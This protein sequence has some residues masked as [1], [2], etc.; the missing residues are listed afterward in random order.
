MNSLWKM[1]SNQSDALYV[2]PFAIIE[3]EDRLVAQANLEVDNF[4]SI[5]SFKDDQRSTELRLQANEKFE[6]NDWYAAMD[7]YTKSLCNAENDSENVA[8]AYANRSACFFH[9]HKYNE[10]LIDIELA[11]Q[12]NPP[13]ILIPE[14]NARKYD[15]ERKQKVPKIVTPARKLSYESNERFPCLADVVELK[16]NMEFGR[17]L[18]ATK[19]IPVGE[20]VLVEEDFVTLKIIERSICCTCFRT[21]VNFIPC[22]RCPDAVF[23][24]SDCIKRNRTHQWECGTFFASLKRISGFERVA[25]EI[26]ILLTT[27]A[28]F[29]DVQELMSFVE[30][31]LHEDPNRMPISLDDFKSKYRFFFKLETLA[32]DSSDDLLCNYFVFKIIMEIPKIA[33]LFDSEEKRRF[34]MHLTIHHAHITNTNSIGNNSSDHFAMSIGNVFSMLNHSCSPNLQNYAVGNRHCCVTIRPIQKGEQLYI[35]YRRGDISTKERQK[36]LKSKWGFDCKCDK[37]IP[38]GESIGLD[39]IESD[40]HFHI[41]LQNLHD[42][43]FRCQVKES[44]IEFL[45]KYGRSP[46]T[47]EIQMIVDAYTSLLQIN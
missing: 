38:T 2:D 39:V 18:A 13:G 43:T 45:N 32:A 31:V 11:E 30:S 35:A 12:S 47:K 7:L 26:Q 28:I 3:P 17:H 5:K 8:L 15:S 4:K 41:V 14:L 27:I 42:E 23:C 29:P 37:C 46:W 16:Q 25:F 19:D 33:A 6:V 34:L 24:G 1:E 9:Q 20:V 21:G 22:R 10:T 44:C 40:P 36:L